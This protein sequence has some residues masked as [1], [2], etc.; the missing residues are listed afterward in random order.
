VKAAASWLPSGTEPNVP[1][2]I[3]DGP[4]RIGW[5]SGKK[6]GKTESAGLSRPV[7]REG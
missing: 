6:W 4:F 2:E 3:L 1:D 5:H 7:L